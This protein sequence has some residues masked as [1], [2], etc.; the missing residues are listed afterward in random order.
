LSAKLLLSCGQLLLLLLWPMHL[1]L[2]GA[3]CFLIY[4]ELETL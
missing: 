1:A 2:Q 4:M 3:S